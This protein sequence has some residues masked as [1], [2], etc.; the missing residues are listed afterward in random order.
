MNNTENQIQKKIFGLFGSGGFAREIMPL[1]KKHIEHCQNEDP[2]SA[3]EAY[4]VE[5]TPTTTEINS[6]PTISEDAF[7]KI[8]CSERSFS[9]CIA[10]SKLREKVA[11]K[12][13]A[14]GATPINLV[15]HQS[16]IYDCNEIAGGAIICAFTTITSNTKIGKHF[17]AN[18]YSYVA[19]DSIIGDYV[20][21]APNVHCNGNVHIHDHA[22]IGTGAIIKQ[23][24]PEKPLTIGQ[25]AI[26]GMG[27]V[28]TKDVPPFT[29]VVGNPARPLSKSS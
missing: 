21:F 13:I 8:N 19:H 6:Y 11:N 12:C 10:D 4:F 20:T 5:L 9:I 18:I 2:N 23:G 1:L 26:V 27:A 7:F 16:V 22:Y 3:Y 17:H 25:G 15:S 29:T 24:T 14:S 28:V